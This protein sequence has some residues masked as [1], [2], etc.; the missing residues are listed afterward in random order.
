[1]AADF[2]GGVKRGL[3]QRR[4]FRSL[5]SDKFCRKCLCQEG[6]K[7][8]RPVW[9]PLT[10]TDS[11][12]TKARKARRFFIYDFRFSI[13]DCRLS[14]V[15]FNRGGRRECQFMIDDLIELRRVNPQHRTRG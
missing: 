13:V 6:Y 12:T 5:K 8:I 9:I 11:F 14:I 2:S 3:K 1:M 15:D 7:T 4:P 10:K